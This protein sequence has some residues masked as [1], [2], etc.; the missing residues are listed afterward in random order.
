M[1]KESYKSTI[2]NIYVYGE[3]EKN[4][5]IIKKSISIYCSSLSLIKQTL[6][7]KEEKNMMIKI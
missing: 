7:R 4:N 6:L 2:I 3:H 1:R 5:K